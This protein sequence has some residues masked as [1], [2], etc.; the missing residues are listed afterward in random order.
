M[1]HVADH[2]A[3][4]AI[5]NLCR[6][7][8]RQVRVLRSSLEEKLGRILKEDDPV[9]SWFPRHSADLI[10]R[11]KRGVDGKTPEQRRSGK[12]WR[13]PAITIGERLY[14]REVGEGARPLKEGRYIGHHGRTGALLVVPERVVR[15]LPEDEQWNRQGMGEPEGLPLGGFGESPRNTGAWD[16]GPRSRRS[17]GQ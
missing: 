1:F 4:G 8:K 5:E 2:R 17:A 3:N 10:C 6:E 13:K 15:R 14:Y 16:S 9:L 7:I 11:Y 12:Q